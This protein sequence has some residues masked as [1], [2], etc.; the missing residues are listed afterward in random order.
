MLAHTSVLLSP[1]RRTDGLSSSCPALRSAKTLAP[2]PLPSLPP[3]LGAQELHQDG[4]ALCADRAPG[5]RA[6]DRALPRPWAG[7]LHSGLSLGFSSLPG[8]ASRPPA[9]TL[10]IQPPV[11][12]RQRWHQCAGLHG[13][14]FRR[15]KQ[16]IRARKTFSRSYPPRRTR[17]AVQD[18]VVS[19]EQTRFRLLALS[20]VC[21]GA[22]TLIGGRVC[23]RATG[24]AGAEGRGSVGSF[25]S[26]GPLLAGCP[27]GAARSRGLLARRGEV[28]GTACVE[29]RTSARQQALERRGS[30]SNTF[31]SG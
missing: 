4:A 12:P 21:P 26:C 15:D 7:L 10:R 19:M 6:P 28:Q 20:A 18:V 25:C 8:P 3:G 22:S 17:P 24:R 23:G 31:P 2:C 1:G 27:A 14:I 9:S 29:C 5:H 11:L 16:A 13:H 30:C